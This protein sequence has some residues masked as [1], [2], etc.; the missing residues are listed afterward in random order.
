MDKTTTVGHE[1]QIRRN[2]GIGS[3]VAGAC[4][5]FDPYVGMFDLLPDCVGYLLLAYGMTQLADLN[6]RLDEA[7][8]SAR[9]LALVGLGRLVAMFLAYGF[10]S[11]GEQPV[12]M[13]L[14]LFGLGVV[15]T[16][17]VIPML[18]NLSAGL[19]YLGSRH[20][21]TAVFDRGSHRPRP[22]LRT[23][24]ERY[25]TLSMGFF[26]L[27]QAFVI[28]PET[29]VLTHEM[30]GAVA[31]K[32]S[33]LYEFVGF[34]RLMGETAALAVGIAWLVMTVS[35]V[36]KLKQD[37]PFFENLTQLYRT[38]V[39]PRQDLFAM[40]AIK[41]SLTAFVVAMLL[42]LDVYMEGVNILPD[43]LVALCLVVSVLLIRHYA[44][45]NIPALVATTAYGLLATLTWILQFK[46]L[47]LEDTRDIHLDDELHA[48]WVVMAVLIC[49]TSIAFLLSVFLVLRSVYRLACQYTG[50]RTLHEGSTYAA[51]RT[52][53]I[54]RQMKRKLIAVG[55]LSGVTVLSTLVHWVLVP[56]M[57]NLVTMGDPST[58]EV[59]G[60]RLYELLRDGYWFFDICF[61]F[62]LFGVSIHA[63][64]EVRDQMEYC[65]RMQ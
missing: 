34:F 15:E 54:H 4:F 14:T 6:D 39:L 8:R 13:L 63:T 27:R 45:W 30:G 64:G 32:D 25:T 57:P 56:F 28:L 26:I 1:P 29:T 55:V 42:T 41:A 33:V 61:G 7:R 10:V 18:K 17:L 52:Q 19:L 65:S 43:F 60:I 24:T 40:R 12:F 48:R 20:D 46:Y 35:F 37:K 23:I 31:G 2:L 38:Q 51:E 47:T 36:R 3:L 16:I 9:W 50:V 22:H 21:G 53:A 44:G 11:P 5:L 59:V 62:A 49:L 58:S